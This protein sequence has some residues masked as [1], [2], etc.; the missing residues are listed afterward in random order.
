[1]ETTATLRRETDDTVIGNE[2]PDTG[3]DLYFSIAGVPVRVH[4]FFWLVAVLLGMNA[5]DLF[6]LLAWIAAMFLAVLVHE[7]GHAWAMRWYG[8]AP[9]IMLYGLGGLTRFGPRV[10]TRAPRPTVAGRV[11]ISFAGPAAGFTFA[12]VVTAAAL[13]AGYRPDVFL[14]LPYGVMIVV[15]GISSPFVLMFVNYLLFVNVAWGLLNLMP[16]IPLD[17]GQILRELLVAWDPWNGL[18]KAFAV[19]T[20][21][22]VCLAVLFVL[23]GQWFIAILFGYLA[24]SGFQQSR[25]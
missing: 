1:M 10:D 25:F 2:P 20:A 15:Q 17:G 9:S 24:F 7:L 18:R 12:A 11:F 21:T 22:A 4:P 14:G 5:S 16:I 8:H 13:A 23:S 19:S 6:G 3:Y